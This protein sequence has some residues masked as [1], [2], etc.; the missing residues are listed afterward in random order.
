MKIALEVL[1]AAKKR[2]IRSLKVADSFAGR[3]TS[4]VTLVLLLPGS[5]F[6]IL[7]V[8]D[9]VFGGSVELGGFFAVTFLIVT[10]ML[11]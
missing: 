1:T 11:A 5:K 9:L 6:V 4:I 3:A 2:V 7:W 10:L 8:T